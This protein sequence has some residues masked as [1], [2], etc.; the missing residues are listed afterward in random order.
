MKKAICI[1]LVFIFVLSCL[2]GCGTTSQPNASQTT[3]AAATDSPATN[4]ASDP[5]YN[6]TTIKISLSGSE[7]GVDY[8][9]AVRFKEIVEE[10]S[11]GKVKINIF[12]NAQL[13]S[14]NM[15]TQLEL[16]LQGDSFEMA[17]LGDLVLVNAV[18]KLKVINVPFTFSNY[19]QAEKLMDGTGG[20]WLEDSFMEKDIVYLSGIHNG[21]QQLTNNKIPVRA[22]ADLKGMKIRVI[23][24]VQ[25]AMFS[26]FGADPISMSYGEIF[27]ALQNGTIDGE[28]NG[29]QTADA[30]NL[31]EVQEYCTVWNA[32]YATFFFVSNK[33]YYE[34]LNDVTKALID[35]ASQEAALFGRE[36]IKDTEGELR[37]KW[38]AA[39]VTLVE[40]TDAERQVFI[41]AVKD[42]RS[43]IMTEVG[44]EACKAWGVE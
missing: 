31:S 29:F 34:G 20:K 35:E 37:Q 2:I 22:P 9:S 12:S 30:I 27:S 40:L 36:Y 33:N 1:S 21:L 4:A 5:G 11:G 32:T 17:V 44:E 10:K 14:G 18:P 3:S 39:G 7:Q 26:T 25:N 8:L 43:S 13:A 24:D 15:F 6:E 19:E 38:E 23:G 28:V 42:I 41:D 16:L